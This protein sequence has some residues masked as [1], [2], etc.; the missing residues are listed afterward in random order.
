MEQECIP[1]SSK[2][3]KCTGMAE[4]VYA[5]RACE[6]TRFRSPTALRVLAAAYAEAGRLNEAARAA[7]KALE[8]ARAAGQEAL[9]RDIARQIK[10]YEQR[11][12]PSNR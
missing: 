8:L 5:T 10:L 1:S 4:T 11:E 2:I 9:A 3:L 6:L 12:A 7:T